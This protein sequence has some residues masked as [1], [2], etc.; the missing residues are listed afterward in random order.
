M[1]IINFIIVLGFNIYW[2][3]RYKRDIFI[4]Y[5][6]KASIWLSILVWLYAGWGIANLI[7]HFNN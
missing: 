1:G 2:L 4:F 5:K 7:Y 6:F 3:V